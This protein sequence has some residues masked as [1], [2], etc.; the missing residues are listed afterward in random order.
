[1]NRTLIARSLLLVLPLFAASCIVVLPPPKAPP[2]A[3]EEPKPAKLIVEPALWGTVEEVATGCEQ[4]LS[5]AEALREELV[6]T[7]EARDQANTL[8]PMNALLI[9]LDRVLPIAQ[10]VANTHPEK[11]VREA[12]EKCEQKAKK[13]Y[14]ALKRDRTVYDA[15]KAVK[16]DGLD[17]LATR[18]QRLLLREYHRAGVDKDEKTRA[19]L[20]K[21][22]EQM[23]ALGQQFGRNIRED[24]KTMEVELKK[25]KG[26]PKDF[27]DARKKEGKATVTLSTD[28]PDFIP[29]QSY[30]AN[31]GVRRKMYE[32]FLTRAYP[33]NDGVLGKLLAARHEFATLLGYEDWAAYNSED[34]MVKDKKTISDFIQKVTGLARPRMEADLKEILKRK[35][36]DHPP[37]KIVGSWDRFYYVNKIKAEKFGVDPAEVR[38]YF[39]F[40]KVKPGL[41]AVAQQLFNLK[42]VKAEGAR[43]WHES[44]EAYDVFEG[45]EH[46]ARFYLDLHPREGKYKHAAEFPLYPGIPGVQLPSAALVTNFPD[47]S[48]TGG[49]PAL[50]EHKQ[51]VTFFHEFGHLMHQLLAGRHHWVTLSGINCEWDFVEAPSQLLEEWAWDHGVL[52]RFATH[53]ET[54]KAIPE[55]LV[56][57]M[58]EARSFGKG[59]HIMRQMFYAALSFNYHNKAPAGFEL[60]KEMRRVQRGYSPYPYIPGT[61]VYANFGH[62]NGYSSMYYTYMWSLVQ[63]KDMLSSFLAKGLMDPGTALAYRKAILEPGGTVDA[64]DMVKTFLGRPYAFDAYQKWLAK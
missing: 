7:K 2:V 42:F 58:S 23:V 12:A 9:Q 10:L 3:K 8:E 64:A 1:M 36:K 62:L 33:V 57:R 52:S 37:A 17:P 49:K 24:R 28:Y 13:Y 53:H 50:T 45:E 46:I 29:V 55:A 6:G 63:A 18:F 16:A 54:G 38:A 35:K 60:M 21:L 5:G 4:H 26:L 44:V 61:A 11:V 31:E 39:D 14:D 40:A 19:R 59:V 47:P 20:A 22:S 15:L 48:K 34:K 51:V 30:A 25:L 32:L 43:V 56:K 41:L 27:V